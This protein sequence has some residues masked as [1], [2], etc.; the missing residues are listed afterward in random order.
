MTEQNYVY[1]RRQGAVKAWINGVEFDS[2]AQKQVFN[3]AD[4][5]FIHEHVA[6]MPDVHG[7]IG[8]TVGSSQVPLAGWPPH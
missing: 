2:M 8:A 7:G 3:T 1:M 5:P 6:V 4:M